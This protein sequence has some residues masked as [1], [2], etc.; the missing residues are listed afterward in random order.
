MIDNTELQRLI[1]LR[2]LGRQIVASLPADLEASLPD[3]RYV[4]ELRDRRWSELPRT[5]YT[6]PPRDVD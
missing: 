1:R 6:V 2:R 5:G 4:G 3:A